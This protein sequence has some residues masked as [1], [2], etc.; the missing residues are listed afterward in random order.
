MSAFNLGEPMKE[1]SNLVSAKDA[2]A[3]LGISR[4]T[5]SRLIRDS[6]IGVYR[7]GTRTLFDE[8]ILE[9][10]KESVFVAPQR[11]APHRSSENV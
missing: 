10:F 4:P 9:E 11:K 5:L 3:R 7:V 6:R 8:K 2:A 1:K